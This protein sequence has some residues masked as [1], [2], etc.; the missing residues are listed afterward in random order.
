MSMSYSHLLIPKEK[1]D[2][3]PN[4]SLIFF[5]KVIDNFFDTQTPRIMLNNYESSK[6]KKVSQKK[7]NNGGTL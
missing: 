4:A 7:T 3:L 1:K 2:V 5:Q 6:S